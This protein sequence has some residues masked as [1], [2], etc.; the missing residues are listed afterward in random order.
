MIRRSQPSEESDTEPGKE[1]GK[2]NIA[3]ARKRM[4]FTEVGEEE[5]GEG[6]RK[7]AWNGSRT[8]E[9]L[10]PILAPSSG[11]MI[12]GGLADK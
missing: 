8:P 12:Q 11:S 2:K 6:R 1:T 4:H 3:P 9:Q 5:G 10:H 7:E